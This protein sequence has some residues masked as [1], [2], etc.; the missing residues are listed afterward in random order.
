MYFQNPTFT[1]SDPINPVDE[2]DFSSVSFEVKYSNFATY[3]SKKVVLS[4]YTIVTDN[5]YTG[6]NNLENF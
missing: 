6:N 5:S 2:L 1:L 4:E 3:K